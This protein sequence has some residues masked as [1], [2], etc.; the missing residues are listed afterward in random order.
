MPRTSQ[1]PRIGIPNQSA[2]YPR[3]EQE[4]CEKSISASTKV[5][6]PMA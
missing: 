2:Q 6:A 4:T 1:N 3:M 5:L